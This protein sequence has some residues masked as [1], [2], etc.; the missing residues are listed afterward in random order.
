MRRPTYRRWVG[1]QL[2]LFPLPLPLPAVLVLE[3]ALTP[4]LVSDDRLQEWRQP[5]N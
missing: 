5:W 4:E 1:E 2:R 3:P